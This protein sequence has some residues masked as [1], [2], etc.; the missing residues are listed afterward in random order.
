MQLLATCH[1]PSLPADG[2]QWGA[3]CC[4]VAVQHPRRQLGCFCCTVHSDKVI[5]AQQ[6]RLHLLSLLLPCCN[7]SQQILLSLLLLLLLELLLELELTLSLYAAIAEPDA[8][9]PVHL[10]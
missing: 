9:A 2:P 6:T 3:G 4:R 1:Q 10:M 7:S 5:Q 8:T